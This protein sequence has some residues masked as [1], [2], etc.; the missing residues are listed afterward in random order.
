[1]A[2]KV[3]DSRMPRRFIAASRMTRT[4]ANVASWPLR[5]STAEAA[6]CAPDEI[7]TAT[8]MPIFQDQT[9]ADAPA[10]DSMMKISSGAY[11]TD[12]R[13]SLAKTGRAMRLGRR[14]SPSWELRSFWPSRIRLA[15]SPTLTSEQDTVQPCMW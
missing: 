15:T 13:A 4:V 12:E 7:D 9:Y 6:Y 2:K 1:M 10:S 14:V 3:P 5:A 8:A 11:A